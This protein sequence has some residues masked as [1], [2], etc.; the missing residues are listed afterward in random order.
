MRRAR[1]INRTRLARGNIY[2]E[3]ELER[4]QREQQPK[5]TKVSRDV[6]ANLMGATGVGVQQHPSTDSQ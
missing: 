5:K 1:I 4:A 3:L 2:R 6:P